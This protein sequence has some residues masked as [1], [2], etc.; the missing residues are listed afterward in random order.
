[1]KALKKENEKNTHNKICFDMIEP[2]TIH[3]GDCLELMPQI[4]DKSVDMVL[5][6]LP[7]Q[8]LHKNNPKSQWDRVIPFEPLWKQYERIIKDNGAIV[9][10]CQ[11]M[12]T[13]QLLMSNPKLWKYNL[14]WE[15]GRATGFLNANR[16]PMRSHEDIAVF[17]RKQCVYNPQWRKEIGR[18]HV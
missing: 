6:D 16:M 7:Y 17:Y 14:V 3:C 8:V 15:K 4:A 12:F 11:G 5:C 18:A 13:A 2:N 1:M 10:F 9:L